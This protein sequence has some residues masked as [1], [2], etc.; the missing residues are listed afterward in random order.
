[1][2]CDLTGTLE[3]SY[4]FRPYYKDKELEDYFK[5]QLKN[6]RP[7]DGSKTHKRPRPY[8]TDGEIVLDALKDK[9]R[10][11]LKPIVERV[12]NELPK[13]LE[14]GWTRTFGVRRYSKDAD[15]DDTY[16][17]EDGDE[18]NGQ[19]SE[20]DYYNLDHPTTAYEEPYYVT[21][22]VIVFPKTKAHKFHKSVSNKGT[23][24]NFDYNHDYVEGNYPR[25]IPTREKK[26]SDSNKFDTSR[27]YK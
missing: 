17:Y 27:F 5:Q 6:K 9:T 14:K 15:L 10:K 16:Y 4:F 20:Y 18:D 24:L 8:K 25:R 23:D 19:A 3:L 22:N 21:D 11:L 12:K 2:N 1:M 13:R 26:K 7:H